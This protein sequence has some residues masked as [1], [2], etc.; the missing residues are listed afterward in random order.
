MKKGIERLIEI[1]REEGGERP[2]VFL[3]TGAVIQFENEL[4]ANE[5]ARLTSYWLYSALAKKFPIYVSEHAL[6]EICRHH[7]E[8]IIGRRPEI[9]EETHFIMENLHKDYCSF[10]KQVRSNPRRLDEVR[11]DVL[12]AGQIA[13]IVRSREHEK[14]K[15]KEGMSEIDREILGTAAFLRYAVLEGEKP[16]TSSI[17]LST[18]NLL[19]DCAHILCDRFYHVF[20]EFGKFGYD[21][22]KVFDLKN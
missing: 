19:I 7:K 21:N 1:V 9:S 3:D 15:N 16:I 17:I 14:K 20:E 8:H 18:D 2:L 13:E 4:A 22:V 5:N 10:L 12:N 6:Q 11:Y